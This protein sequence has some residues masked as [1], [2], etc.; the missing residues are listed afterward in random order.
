M[1]GLLQADAAT[2][3]LGTQRAPFPITELLLMQSDLR[4]A[5]PLYTPLA[6]FALT[7]A[8]PGA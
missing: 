2:S 3:L 1:G 7:G 5:G 4:P 8:V 6:R